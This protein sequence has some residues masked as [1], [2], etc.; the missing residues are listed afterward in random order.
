MLGIENREGINLIKAANMNGRNHRSLIWLILIL[1]GVASRVDAGDDPARLQETAVQDWNA[2]RSQVLELSQ[3]TDAPKM[4]E[5]EG[6]AAEGDIKPIYFDGL[7]WQ[8]KP[9]R[10]FA[11]LGMPQ[12]NLENPGGKVPGVV[13]VH[14]GGGTAFKEWV[15]KWNEQG[16]AAIA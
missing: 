16:F 7:P 5:A 13:L 10:I 8:G 9:T 14:G 4:Y 2:L 6:F 1:C 11:W 15:K 3:L 12:P